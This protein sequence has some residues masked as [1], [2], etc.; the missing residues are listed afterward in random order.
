MFGSPRRENGSNGGVED[1]LK[2]TEE[3]TGDTDQ[4]CA[5]LI[6]FADNYSSD[7]CQQGMLWQTSSHTAQLSKS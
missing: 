2:S 6:D 7:E 3:V 5:A 1:R 4:Y